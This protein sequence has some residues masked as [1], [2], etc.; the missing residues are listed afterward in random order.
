MSPDKIDQ[1]MSGIKEKVIMQIER[2]KCI[3][4]VG[5]FC[6]LA[7]LAFNQTI[8]KIGETYI[9]ESFKR[10]LASFAIARS[11]NG[12]ISVAQGTEVAV[13]PAGLGVNFTPG[14]ILDPINDLIERFSWAMLAAGS[15]LGVQKVLLEISAWKGIS[16]LLCLVSVIFCY[17]NVTRSDN[18]MSGFTM[19]FFVLLLFLRFAM[20]VSALANEGIYRLFLDTSYQQANKTLI[21]TQERLGKINQEWSNSGK[22]KEPSLIDRAQQWFDQKTDQL[23]YSNQVEAFREAAKNA[24]ESAINMI[25][26]FLMQTLILPLLFMWILVKLTKCVFIH[27]H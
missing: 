21:E 5:M 7:F 2:R 10:S 20:P 12:V 17:K 16:I 1:V 22:E 19:R 18:A 4:L 3:A 13:Q 24:T 25:V 11:I 14:Q 23:S 6:L 27:N 26:V 9:N 15:S 8:D